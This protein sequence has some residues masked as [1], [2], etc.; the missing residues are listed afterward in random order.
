M[1]KELFIS[2][3]EA[4]KKQWKYDK[5]V[6][7]HLSKAFPNA[8]SGNVLPENE[9]LNTAIITILEDA[10]NDS[11][12]MIEWWCWEAEFGKRF[13]DVEEDGKTISVAN[14]GEL[15]DFL[16]RNK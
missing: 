11:T 13:H 12:E 8:N 9:I 16:K 2:S 7:K 6:A 4:I 10:M 14:A 1:K 5:K 3:I 15:Y